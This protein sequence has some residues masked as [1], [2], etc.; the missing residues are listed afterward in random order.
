LFGGNA[1]P[2]EEEESFAKLAVDCAI[3]GI[4]V[5]DDVGK[6]RDRRGACTIVFGAIKGKAGCP[7]WLT[8]VTGD[9]D[10]PDGDVDSADEREPASP[11]NVGFVVY[12]IGAVGGVGGLLRPRGERCEVRYGP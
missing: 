9:Q 12:E 7:I 11:R 2:L 10:I 1:R 4:K 3:A 8:D 5:S 6:M